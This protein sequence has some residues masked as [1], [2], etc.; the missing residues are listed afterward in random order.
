MSGMKLIIIIAVLGLM[1]FAGSFLVTQW[2]GGSA[3][4][5]GDQKAE[6]DQAGESPLAQMES[7]TPKQRQLEELIRDVRNRIEELRHQGRR[8]DEREKRVRIAQQ[9]LNKEAQGLANLRVQLAAPLIRLDEMIKELD[10][11]RLK[12]TAEERVSLKRTAK[13]YEKMESEKGAEILVAMCGGRQFDDAVKIISYMSDKAAARILENITD[14]TL[15]PRIIE[16]MKKV[17]EEG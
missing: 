2:L 10:N 16:G 12:I 14:K 15:G 6:Q 3:P 9:E 17:R 13:I 4:P 8:L 5:A 7:L 1:G 11:S